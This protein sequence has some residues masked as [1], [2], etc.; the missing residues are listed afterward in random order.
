M[1]VKSLGSS[2][3]IVRVNIRNICN[4]P[5]KLFKSTQPQ[6]NQ[7]YQT[8]TTFNVSIFVV[9]EGFA[10][11]DVTKNPQNLKNTLQRNHILPM[12]GGLE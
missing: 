9:Q 8:K 7:L 12:F 5:G 6:T 4:R 11:N 3:P 2:V 10:K 1:F